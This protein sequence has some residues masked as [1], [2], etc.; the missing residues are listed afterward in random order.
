MTW[1]SAEHVLDTCR[2]AMADQLCDALREIRISGPRIPRKYS[3]SA[4]I[5]SIE[6]V[7]DILIQMICESSPRPDTTARIIADRIRRDVAELT[8]KGDA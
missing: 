2:N 3:E 6:G 7:A 4:V 1:N 8:S 5:G